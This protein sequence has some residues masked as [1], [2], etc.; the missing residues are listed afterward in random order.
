MFSFFSKSKQGTSSGFDYSLLGTDMHSHLLPGI[1]DGSPSLD[2]S[3]ELI[4]G[5]A[6]LGYKRLFSVET[7]K[8]CKLTGSKAKRYTRQ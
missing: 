8:L 6:G 4:R 1:D 5:M 2:V 3:L 7:E